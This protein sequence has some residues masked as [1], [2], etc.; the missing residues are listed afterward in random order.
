MRNI[1][2]QPVADATEGERGKIYATEA[3]NVLLA[4]GPENFIGNQFWIEWINCLVM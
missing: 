2:R 1:V 4:F 3:V